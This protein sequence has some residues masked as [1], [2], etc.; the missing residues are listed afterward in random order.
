MSDLLKANAAR[1]QSCLAKRYSFSGQVLTLGEWLHT[2]HAL[3]PVEKSEGDGMIG[4]SRTRFNRMDGRQQDDY[5]A[6]LRAKHYY[7][8]NSVQVPKIVFDIV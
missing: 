6:S 1:L 2:Q 4:W 5:E 8:L 3:G 7:Y